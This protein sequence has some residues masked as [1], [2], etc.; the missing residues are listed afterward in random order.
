MTGSIQAVHSTG[1]T[2]RALNDRSSYNR[3]D[4]IKAL[5]QAKRIKAKY[6]DKRVVILAM[7][8]AQLS[9]L[10]KLQKNTEQT[11]KI[12]ILTTESVQGSQSHSV[13]MCPSLHGTYPQE[14][15]ASKW[16]CDIKRL[17]MTISRAEENYIIV[18]N[19]LLLNSIPAYRFLIEIAERTGELHCTPH[20]KKIIQYDR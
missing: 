16:A 12:P 3:V 13:I 15:L 9:L 1:I 2:T 7:Y 4:A 19:L 11:H 6:P 14:R 8:T 17:C 20:I 5:Q 10:S 18:G